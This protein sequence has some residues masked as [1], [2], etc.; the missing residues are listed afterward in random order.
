MVPENHDPEVSRTPP[1]RRPLIVNPHRKRSVRV[2]VLPLALIV[3][4]IVFLPRLIE[5]WL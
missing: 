5:R 3:A 1:R 2:W 4:V